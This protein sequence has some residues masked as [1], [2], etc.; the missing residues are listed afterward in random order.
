MNSRSSLGAFFSNLRRKRII[1][2]L[3]AFIG[4]GWLIIEFVDRILVAHYHFPDRTIDITFITL[5]CA[6]IC[7]LLWRWFSGREEP[8]KFKLELVLIPLVVLITV[9]L[10]INLILHLK[11]PEYES[12]PASKWKNSIAILPFENI[13]PEEGQDYFCNGLTDDLIT[14]LNNVKELK[15]IAKASAYSLK[16][17]D[18]RDIGKKLNVA[19]VLAGGVRK[20]GNKLRITAQLISVADAS[21][22]WSDKYDRELKDVFAI[23][24]GIATAIVDALRL[25][26]TTQEKK[27][28]AEHQIDNLAAYECYLRATREI[29]SYR[30]DALDPALR[31]LQNGVAMIGDNALLYAAIAHVYWQY[32]NLGAKQEEYIEKA[33]EY[34]NKALS[35]DA[36]FPTAHIVV[37]L[38]EQA[39]RGKQKDAVRH[40]KKALASAPNESEALVWLANA[41]IQYAGKISAAVP[42]LE[43]LQQLDPLNPLLYNLLGAR[44]YYEGRYDLAL[45][46]LHKGNQMHPGNIRI[47]AYYAVA[48]AHTKKVD[49]AFIIIDQ[50]E[51]MSRDNGITKLMLMLK[52]ALLGDKEKAFREMTP[53][54]QRS[55]KRDAHSS[56][57]VAIAMS[58]LDAKKEAFDWLENAVN[59]GFINYPLLAEKDPWFANIRGEPRFKKLME[60][61]KYEW[62]HFE[63]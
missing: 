26:L 63:E 62:E 18:V 30:Q 61:V 51:K 21:L 11:G 22:I 15:V 52:Y 17:K 23:Q 45:E 24:D 20:A 25:K 59:R 33:E 5:L 47:L 16:E 29:D 9:L 32:V 12:I 44:Y 35:I 34:V 53:D 31:Y 28:I 55:C 57:V 3:A 13:S 48:L 6:L 1:E 41:Y 40:F 60:R 56:E 2:I 46:P 4:G 38:I 37:G 43:K 58:L 7:T 42:L 14:R 10:D 27:K 49:E 36:D 54:F 50:M 39:F 19:T 8:R